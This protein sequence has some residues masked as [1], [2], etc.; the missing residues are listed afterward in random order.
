MTERMEGQMSIFDLDSW[1]GKMSL[2]PYHQTTEKTSESSS[3]RSA[4]SKIKP[5]MYLD[6]RRANGNRPA[7]SWE[8]G[9][10]WLGEY[11]MHSFGES[12]KEGVE[13]HLSQILQANPVP[14][15]YYLSE[16]ACRGILARAEKRCKTLP[17]QLQKALENQAKLSASK[18]VP[19]SLGGGKGILIQNDRTGA[20]S[21]LNRQAVCAFEPGAASRVGGHVYDDGIAGTVGANA[22]DNQ[23]SIC[24]GIS[25]Y[26]SNAM[27]SS[28]PNSGVYVADT[29]RT[30]DNNGGNPSC[31][32]G[33]VAVVALE[34]NGQRPSHRGDGY[35]EKGVSFTLNSTEV[36]AVAVSGAVEEENDA[37]IQ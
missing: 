1:S 34:G 23:Q 4:V 3:K 2:E 26:D 7:V 13:S 29:S 20:L 28:N 15:K 36:H 14:Q 35:S 18:N 33:G 16:K 5:P 11:M 6:L 10:Q 12:P 21:T 24:Y 22:G 37:G 19:E 32:Q 25:S 8:T 27:K 30:L 9:F 17:P 31:N